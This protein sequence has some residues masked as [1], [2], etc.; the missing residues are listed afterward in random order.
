MPD[1]PTG[2]RLHLFIETKCICGYVHTLLRDKVLDGLNISHWKCA[3]CKRRFVIACVPG[4][5]ETE[6]H[7]WPIYLEQVPSSGSTVEDGVSQSDLVPQIGPGDLRFKCRC[8]CPLLANSAILG[9][10]CRC[11]RCVSKLIVRAAPKGLTGAP[12]A[13]LEYLDNP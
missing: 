4:A 7:F 10:P 9:R 11:P 13:I 1:L 12:S 8:G 6:D 2:G 5:N 3:A